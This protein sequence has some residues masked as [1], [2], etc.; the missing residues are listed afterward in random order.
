VLATAEPGSLIV[1][2][3]G[4]LQTMRQ[5]DI[6]WEAIGELTNELMLDLKGY[7][8]QNRLGPHRYEYRIEKR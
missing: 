6:R 4:D 3:V 5:V 7:L 1:Y 8:T 2:A